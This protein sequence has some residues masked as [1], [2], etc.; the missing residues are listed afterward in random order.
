[1]WSRPDVALQYGG[2][3]LVECMQLFLP[4]GLRDTLTPS[5]VSPD[6]APDFKQAPAATASAE[7]EPDQSVLAM[8]RLGREHGLGAGG[9]AEQ[10]TPPVTAHQLSHI[11]FAESHPKDAH[12]MDSNAAHPVGRGLK[13]LRNDNTGFNTSSAAHTGTREGLSARQLQG[14]EVA[15]ASALRSLLL[16]AADSQSH[17][18]QCDSRTTI[19]T[20]WLLALLLQQ[21][22]QQKQQQ[23][24]QLQPH[25]HQEQQNGEQQEQ[26]VKQQP[27]LFP[28]DPVSSKSTQSTQSFQSPRGP[29]LAH[30]AHCSSSSNTP[31][32]A[33]P[34]LEWPLSF[35]TSLSP[36]ITPSFA[37]SLSPSLAPSV[38]P[39]ISPTHA[40]TSR[41]YLARPL[42]AMSPWL[43]S[44]RKPFTF[45]MTQS[46]RVL[47]SARPNSLSQ[48]LRTTVPV[49]APTAPPTVNPIAPHN[50]LTSPPASIPS[51]SSHCQ[52]AAPLSPTSLI[53]A[54]TSPVPSAP[55]TVTNRG[56]PHSLPSFPSLSALQS[57]LHTPPIKAP[58]TLSDPSH[59]SLSQH[60]LLQRY[61]SR[62]ASPSNAASS[63]SVDHS[64]PS[65]ESSQPSAQPSS[66]L[67]SLRVAAVDM[68]SQQLRTTATPS[69]GEASFAPHPAATATS[70]SVLPMLPAPL[71]ENKAP[72]ASLPSALHYA[73]MDAPP[74]SQFALTAEHMRPHKI[75][76]TSRGVLPPA[77][78]EFARSFFS[79]M[80][81]SDD[82]QGGESSDGQQTSEPT[83][84]SARQDSRRTGAS[85]EGQCGSAL[86]AAA[87]GI[88]QGELSIWKDLIE[89]EGAA[90]EV[91]CGE[92]KRAGLAVRSFCELEDLL[93]ENDNLM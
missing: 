29:A 36:S 4:P 6:H 82:P 80:P 92:E 44:S 65:S 2:L 18:R 15:D 41:T 26:H 27:S 13:R 62:S 68:G 53:T 20:S 39:S 1:M 85:K 79:G 51:P 23:Q 47:H 10:G 66:Q 12:P 54:A 72:A 35:S 76:R 59:Q 70:A 93:E 11:L 30:A 19:P 46:S 49:P 48:S 75:P 56:P 91:V 9:G 71:A 60:H 42:S 67:S 7:A 69:A 34:A 81:G 8:K 14:I 83:C 77:A 22:Q 17:Q 61:A 73:T 16:R 87:E 33:L 57:A 32:S 86:A 28:Q 90:E 89:L 24:Q 52:S 88:C 64:P 21:K 5:D 40:S 43:S 37:P 38:A 74:L 63:A 25:Q 84:A 78:L 31:T 45:G 58:P 55:S 50:P 3:S